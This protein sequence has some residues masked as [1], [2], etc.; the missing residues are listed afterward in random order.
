MRDVSKHGE[1]IKK[2]R[3]AIAQACEESN[4]KALYDGVKAS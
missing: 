3:K 4:Y 1:K 2:K